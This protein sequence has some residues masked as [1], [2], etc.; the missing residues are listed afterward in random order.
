[1]NRLQGMNVS[2]FPAVQPGTVF[3]P[4]NVAAVQELLKAHNASINLPLRVVSS[5][6]NWGLG[7]ASSPTPNTDLVHLHRLNKIR[8]IDLERGFAVVEAGV[9]QDQLS[10]ELQG[11]SRFLNCTASSG[12]TSIV[13]N[14]MDRGVGLHGQR[15]HDLLGVEVV[16][17][18]GTAGTVGW[19]PNVGSLAANRW[20]LGPSSLHLFTQSNFAVVTAA[21]ISLRPRPSR[22]E[23]VTFTVDPGTMETVVDQLRTLVGDGILSGVTKI[24]DEESSS[25]YGARE[26]R[27]AIHACIDGPEQIAEAKISE[28]W[29]RLGSIQP[30][31]VPASKVNDDPLMSAVISLYDGDTSNSETIVRNALNASTQ[32]AD[33]HGTGWIFAL[34]FLPM[35]GRDV[36]KAIEIVRQSIVGTNVRA[37]TTVNVLD[38]DTVDLVVALSFQ[39]D[40]TG[41]NDAHQVFDRMVSKLVDSGYAPYRVDTGHTREDYADQGRSIDALLAQRISR[42]IDPTRVFASNRY[43]T[44]GAE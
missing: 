3:E 38:H 11:T 32:G 1:M 33:K 13:G 26:A 29:R 40:E 37:G 34:P 42:V 14:M 23:I 12:Q 6:Y 21:T 15:T 18:D 16:L 41:S 36:V 43:V 39:R 17:P 31:R 24:Y 30:Q 2:E 10:A 27:I 9:T 20:G 5:G 7:S 19:W 35:H 4:E 25:L 28:L 44:A 22:R 8:I